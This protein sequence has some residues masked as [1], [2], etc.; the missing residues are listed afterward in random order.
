MNCRLL[1]CFLMLIAALP[2]F[3]Q[4]APLRHYTTANAH[5]HNDYEKPE[6][7]HKAWQHGFGSIE[8][9]IYLHNGKLI[10]AHDSAQLKRQRTLD[11]LYLQPLQKYLNADTSRSLQLMIDIKSAALVTLD[12]LVETLKVYPQLIKSSSLKI[13]ISGNRPAPSQFTSYPSWIYFDGELRREYQ[14]QEL[15]KIV[16]VSDNYARYKNKQELQQQIDRAHSLGKKIRFWNAP[17]HPES[18]KM[19]IE[20]GVDYI[21]TDK[22]EELSKFLRQL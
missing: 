16:M 8:A 14:P 20:L 9:D 2:G 7:L 1:L 12:K 4:K 17:D 5:S 11:S 21:N 13:V 3:S 6:P 18:W 10:V 15:E 22:I 19:F